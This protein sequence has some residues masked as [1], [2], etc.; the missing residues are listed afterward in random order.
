M[1]L[2]E[3]LETGSQAI[4]GVPRHV[5]F[6]PSLNKIIGQALDVV[7]K[8]LPPGPWPGNNVILY[9]PDGD[10]SAD[11]IIGRH[12][13]GPVPDGLIG[14]ALPAGTAAHLRHVG[15]VS[16]RHATHKAIHRWMRERGHKT[17][18]LNWEIYGDWHEDPEQRVVDVYYL[19]DPDQL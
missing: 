17:V 7:Y 15:D 8:G 18:G 1:K 9:S 16:R 13:D 14:A 11:L 12:Y 5:T 10:N 4:V 3:V 2:I 6:G 19:L